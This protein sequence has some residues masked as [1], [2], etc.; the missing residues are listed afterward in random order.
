MTEPRDGDGRLDLRVLLPTQV[1]LDEP[2]E[3]VLAQGVDGAFCLLPRHVDFV[4]ALV[5]GILTFRAGDGR[6]RYAAIDRGIL[7]KCGRRVSV[8]CLGGVVGGRLEDLRELVEE[9]FLVLDEH[10]R[11]TR[12]ALARLELGTLRAFQLLREVPHG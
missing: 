11:K 9:R 2:V 5:P 1:L 3:R 12:S 10:E 4:S 8:S 6:E 7:V